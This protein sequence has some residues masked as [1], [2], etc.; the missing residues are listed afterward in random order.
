MESERRSRPQ[1]FFSSRGDESAPLLDRTSRIYLK[2][3][4]RG[5]S[6]VSLVRRASAGS[7]RAR[8]GRMHVRC[9]LTVLVIVVRTR[10]GA[11]I[12]RARAGAVPIVP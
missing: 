1:F 11:R 4:A 5:G 7:G 6:L 12:I 10:E 8:T 3:L 9:H 2:V